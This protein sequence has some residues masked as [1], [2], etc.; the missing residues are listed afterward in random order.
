MG[1][2][3]RKLILSLF[4]LAV[5]LACTVTTTYAWFARNREAWIDDFELEFDSSDGMLISIDGE[6]FSSGI[7]LDQVKNEIKRRTNKEYKDIIYEG[8]TPNLDN[9][10]HLQYN[11]DGSIKMIKD[12]LTPVDE[13]YSTHSMVAADNDDYLT[14]DVYFRIYGGFASDGDYK[15][16][17]KDETSLTGKGERNVELYADATDK[18]GV[19]HGPNQELK[20]ISVDPVNAMRF[21]F[22]QT[23]D[24]IT[25]TRIY[26]PGLGLGSA[27]IEGSTDAI[28]D[29]NKNA[30]YTYY[31]NLN[32]FE[33]FTTAASDGDSF[34]TVKIY[35]GKK[36][37]DDVLASF[38]Y[39]EE[40]KSFKDIKLTFTIWLE[41]WDADCF[42]GIPKD[43]MQF[44]MRLSFELVE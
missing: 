26:E 8:V 38:E 41:G 3:R 14:F 36:Y 44:A 6:N 18:N 29:K 40:S 2:I 9:N 30:M 34:D 19:V 31:N 25:E 27:A 28:H 43:I 32:Q 11:D 17:L 10:G 4:S 39:D 15:L 1:G 21:A 22:S 12:H 24:N 20:T 5:V 7:T 37:S 16:K 23:D 13:Y 35:E 42:V 33:K